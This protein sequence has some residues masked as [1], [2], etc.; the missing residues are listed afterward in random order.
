MAKKLAKVL[1]TFFSVAMLAACGGQAGQQA[2][3][4]LTESVVEQAAL[5]EED[6]RAIQDACLQVFQLDWNNVPQEAMKD[7][8]REYTSINNGAVRFGDEA[9]STIETV[10]SFVIEM[11]EAYDWMGSEVSKY[12]SFD[13]IDTTITEGKRIDE[14]FQAKRAAISQ[15]INQECQPHFN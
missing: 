12:I 9:R 13:D 6:T 1:F 5:S 3:P 11:D 4:S 10:S 15:K 8:A 7:L 14:E 2:S